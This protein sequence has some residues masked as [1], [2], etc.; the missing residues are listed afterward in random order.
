MALNK[1]AKASRTIALVAVRAV[2][3][4]IFAF[5]S[6][7]IF[8]TLYCGLTDR[9]SRRTGVAV[10][11]VIG[12]SIVYWRNGWKCP[13]TDVAEGLGAANGTVGDIF[14]PGW[15]TPRI[16]VISSSLFGV[17]LLAMLWHRVR[18]T[19]RIGAARP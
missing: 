12:E 11:A 10:A 19:G 15:L 4:I 7:S 17:G 5:M 13:L 6:G 8:Y 14:L 3:T 1:E 9:V 18:R 16:P 2:H